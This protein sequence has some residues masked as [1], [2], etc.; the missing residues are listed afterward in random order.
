MLDDTHDPGLTSWVGSANRESAFPIQNL[1]FA[2]F[3]PGGTRE[4]FRIGVAIGDGILD[5]RQCDGLA[6][7]DLFAQPTLNAFMTTGAD[8]WKALRRQ[9][10]RALRSGARE[11]EEW[12]AHLVPRASAEFALPAR[13]G[14]YT[15]FYTSIHHATNIGRLFRPDNPL[16]PNY[17]WIPIGYHGRSS[18]IGVSG[19][20]FHR[21][22]GQTMTPGAEKPLVG[23]SRR[24]D[25]ELELG[26][27]IG[28]GNAQ[29]H[30]IAIESAGDHLFGVCLLNDWSARDVQAWEYQ[31]LGP[32]LSKS[33][34]TTLSPWI[35]TRSEERRVGKE[36]RL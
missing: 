27:V 25:Y 21:P 2:A 26:L 34:A 3:R 31:P 29:G 14:D 8:R 11:A 35:V 5:L 22:N 15:D 16:L 4:A 24:L 20:D 12:R 10:S 17:K 32:F 33:F 18:T 13:I 23:P 19:T 36:C 1:P 30:A 28:Q 9:L 7:R 6:D